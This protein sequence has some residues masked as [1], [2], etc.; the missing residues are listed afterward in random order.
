MNKIYKIYHIP[1]YVHNDG[2]VGKIGVTY[3]TLKERFRKYRNQNLSDSEILERYE[4][5]YKV[6]DREIELQKEYGYKVD[7]ILY[8]QTLKNNTKE[9]SAK[10]GNK[11]VESGR[12]YKIQRLAT[13]ARKRPVLQYDLDG[14]FIKEWE[15]AKYASRTLNLHGP[16]IAKVCKGKYKTT[17]GFVFKYKDEN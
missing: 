16:N 10:G 12:I 2:S 17:G 14:N 15:C 11:T 9:G 7:R 3:T 6:S 5:K 8:W 1:Q 13:E 4:C